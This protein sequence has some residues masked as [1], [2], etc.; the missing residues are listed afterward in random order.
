MFG[1]FRKR[2]VGLR[3]GVSFTDGRPDGAE[4]NGHPAA[5][6]KPKP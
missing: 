2:P 3:R 4:T 5:Q 6:G 1:I